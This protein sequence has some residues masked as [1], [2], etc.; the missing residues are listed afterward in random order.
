MDGVPDCPS[1][2]PLELL[3]AAAFLSSSY[4]EKSE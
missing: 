2:L 4:K 1:S 3:F